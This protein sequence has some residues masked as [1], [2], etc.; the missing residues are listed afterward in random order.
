M[1]WFKVDDRFHS[2]RKVLSLSLAA[3]GLWT[4][5]GS[6]CSANPD[7]R[8]HVPR[9]LL[10]TI[11]AKPALAGELVK[12]GLW[13]TTPDGW[14]F[15]DWDDYQPSPEELE[16]RRDNNASRQ[17]RWRDKRRLDN[18]DRN[19]LRNAESNGENNAS[20]SVTNASPDP[21][22]FKKE[23]SARAH[24][25][26]FERGYEDGL[27]DT[28]SL[29]K[30]EYVLQ[31]SRRGLE[32]TKTLKLDDMRSF[33]Q[34]GEFAEA[35]AERLKITPTNVIRAVLDVFFDDPK[36]REHGWPPTFMR[37]RMLKCFLAHPATQRAL[38]EAG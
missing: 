3:V 36:M 28:A 7:T 25:R 12:S 31:L 1:T 5:A 22:S 27:L 26:E 18:A 19:A 30:N 35:Q 6:W 15:H 29:A 10:Q 8:G 9:V 34:L 16:E 32:F 14:R 21:V 37:D 38:Q 11:G 2:H 33:R 23:E 17:Q 24:E 4:R 20:G 13:E